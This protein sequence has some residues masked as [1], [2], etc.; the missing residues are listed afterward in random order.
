LLKNLKYSKILAPIY[1]LHSLFEKN[2]GTEK[3][4]DEPDGPESIRKF[5]EE[6][7]EYRIRNRKLRG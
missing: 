2:R 1:F 4:A 7:L 3:G 6:S 5:F